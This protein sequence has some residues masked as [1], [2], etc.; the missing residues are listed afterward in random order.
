[1]LSLLQKNVLI[2]KMIH[3]FKIQ[4]I[5]QYF[6]SE[7]YASLKIISAFLV[8]AVAVLSFFFFFMLQLFY[9]CVQVFYILLKLIL[10]FNSFLILYPFDTIFQIFYAKIYIIISLNFYI[11]YR[12]NCSFFCFLILLLYHLFF[13]QYLLMFSIFY[14]SFK[15]ALSSFYQIF[16]LNFT[17]FLLQLSN[18]FLVLQVYFPLIS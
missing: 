2:Q 15:I 10:L 12:C 9:A 16:S 17:N 5:F 8:Y 13:L 11:S 1:M 3:F 14:S 6:T 7:P 18:C 4:R